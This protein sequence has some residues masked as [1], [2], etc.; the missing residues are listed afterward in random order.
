MP[1]ARIRTKVA[2]V[3]ATPHSGYMSG[4]GFAVGLALAGTAGCAAAQARRVRRA[5]AGLIAVL[6]LGM[7]FMSPVNR[8]QW[9]AIYSA[10]RYLPSWVMASP[11]PREIRDVFFVNLPFVNI[12]LKLLDFIRVR[13]CFIPIFFWG[14]V[15]NLNLKTCAFRFS[16]VYGFTLIFIRELKFF[17][18]YFS[19][20]PTP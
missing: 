12:Y 5:T 8:L 11:P 10:E 9:I 2:A 18:L 15:F 14:I 7:A 1:P 3:V 13:G 17:F 20:C 16:F 19:H 6:I 4:V